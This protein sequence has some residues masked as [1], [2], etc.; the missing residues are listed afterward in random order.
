MAILGSS[1]EQRHKNDNNG[2][3]VKIA[4]K[5]SK[6]QKIKFRCRGDSVK[7]GAKQIVA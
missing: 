7:S 3:I 1:A 4:L 2:V 6:P 5:F